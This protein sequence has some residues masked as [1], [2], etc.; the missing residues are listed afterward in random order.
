MA[1]RGRER[2][3]ERDLY[4]EI[5]EG[6]RRGSTSTVSPIM[7]ADWFVATATRPPLYHVI[8]DIPE[9]KVGSATIVSA[10]RPKN[11]LKSS[12]WLS[13]VGMVKSG[14]SGQNRLLEHH[15]SELRLLLGEL[16]LPGDRR[17]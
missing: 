11:N 3:R 4:K 6:V 13:R 5:E 14:V 7:R 12:T 1:E 2:Q 10:S 15:T 16:R 8:A 9:T 17:R